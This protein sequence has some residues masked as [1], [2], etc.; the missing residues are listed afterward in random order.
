M[1]GMY[2]APGSGMAICGGI[3]FGFSFISNSKKEAQMPIYGIAGRL[4]ERGKIKIGWKES[5]ER[6]SRSGKKYRNPTKL[7]HFLIT[8]TEKDKNGFFIKDSQVHEKIGEKPTVLDVT[9]PYET[10]PANFFTT[11]AKYSFSGMKLCSGDGV[12]AVEVNERSQVERKRECP[13]E[14]LADKTC[15]SLGILQVNLSAANVIGGVYTFRTT[16]YWSISGIQGSLEQFVAKGIPLNCIPLKMVLLPMT[17]RVNG[18]PTKMWAAH[19]EFHGND[20][21]LFNEAERRMAFFAALG[22]AAKEMRE[23]ILADAARRLEQASEDEDDPIVDEF[24]PDNHTI[25][26][27]SESAQKHSLIQIDGTEKEEKILDPQTDQSDALWSG[28]NEEA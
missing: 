27:P 18:R 9:L 2:F 21:D 24:Y 7:D 14:S 10:I 19:L 26:L 1:E 13:C 4:R 8:T 23:K 16:S 11:Y 22:P 25:G 3:A 20:Q 17:A 12:S 28:S 15:K 5:Q 6:E